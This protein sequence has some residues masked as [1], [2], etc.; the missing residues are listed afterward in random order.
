MQLS[1]WA[2]GLP[3]TGRIGPITICEYLSRTWPY[4]SC[5]WCGVITS[6][7]S[8]EMIPPF[9]FRDLYAALYYL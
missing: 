2:L 1:P 8:S 9:V 7:I 6:V 4:L 3:F 5:T